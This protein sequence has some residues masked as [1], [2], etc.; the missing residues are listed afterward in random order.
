MMLDIWLGDGV[1][2]KE[3]NAF[4]ASPKTHVGMRQK[5]FDTAGGYFAHVVNLC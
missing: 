1:L 3:Q 2:Y 4:D 5:A